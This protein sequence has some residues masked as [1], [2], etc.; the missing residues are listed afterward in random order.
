M[1]RGAQGT[2]ANGIASRQTTALPKVTP[3]KITALPKPVQA[4]DMAAVAK[5]FAKRTLTAAYSE[6]T[7]LTRPEF[8]R[9]FG[10]RLAYYQLLVGDALNK[11]AFETSLEHSLL[12]T[13]LVVERPQ[14]SNHPG[15]D[16]IIDGQ[17]F[18]LKTE[19]AR[20]IRQDRIHISKLMESAWSKD[21]K[22]PADASRA[23]KRILQ[24][25]EQYDRVLTLRA[26]RGQSEEM[27]ASAGETGEM[28]RY[29]L[30]EIPKEVLTAISQLR[31]KDFGK[32]SAA[33]STRADVTI[34]GKRAFTLLFDGSDNKV[35][36]RGIDTDLCQHHASW[37][38]PLP[39][40]DLN[41]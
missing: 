37:W 9:R 29:D 41:E 23:C 11:Y 17:A 3:R 31:T 10:E 25:L 28:I 30:V 38:V 32:L 5:Q 36:V 4:P 19:A 14:A 7:T 2:H 22:T 24:H 16:L 6:D 33:G 13:G 34:K 15:H 20:Q 1:G 26:F 39:E 18:S 21:F 12:Q 40:V 35:T 8:L 27:A